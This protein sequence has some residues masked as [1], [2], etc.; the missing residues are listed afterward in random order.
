MDLLG[1]IPTY[2]SVPRA[3][4]LKLV[5]GESGYQ[6]YF[7]PYGWWTDLLMKENPQEEWQII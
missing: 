1:Q 2:V 3:P 4:P 6:L 7:I 5:K